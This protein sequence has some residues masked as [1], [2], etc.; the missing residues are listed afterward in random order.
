MIDA[1][2]VRLM[3]RISMY[4]NGQGKKDLKMNRSKKN[5]YIRMKMIETI[6]CVTLAYLI[7]AGL[8]CTRYVTIIVTEGFGQFKDIAAALLA[9]YLILLLLSA[10]M[11]YFYHRDKYKK[12]YQR[13]VYYDKLLAKLEEYIRNN[14]EGPKDPEE[15][16]EEDDL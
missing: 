12:A 5:T 15:K 4:E 8:Y 1:R 13:I 2:K 11:T 14:T 9:I 3:T 7:V 16:K 10:A 6:L